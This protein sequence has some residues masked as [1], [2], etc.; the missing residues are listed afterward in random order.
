[1]AAATEPDT[2]APVSAPRNR[3]V[4]S[5]L[6]W[7]KACAAVLLLLGAMALL[8]YN[9]W[10]LHR[11]AI[12]GLNNPIIIVPGSESCTYKNNGLARLEPPVQRLMYGFAL[13]WKN[14]TPSAISQRL[15]KIAPAVVNAW[16]RFDNNGFNGQ[17]TSDINWFG[18]ETSLLGRGTMLELTML[19]IVEMSTLT[20]ATLTNIAQ[21]CADINS[22]YAVP[23]LL[24]FGHEM[25]GN[26]EPYGQRPSAYVTGFRNM[27]TILRKYTNLTAMVWA[28]NI[29]TFYPYAVSSSQQLPPA[30]SVDF[31]LLDTNSD[32]VIDA[33]DDPYGPYYPGDDVIDWV[34]LS[35]YWYPETGVSSVPRP[36]TYV[37]DSILAA[38]PS[39]TPLVSANFNATL[40]NF[41]NRFALGK[42]KPM[43]FPESGAPYIRNSTT[44]NVVEE[45]EVKQTWWQQVL[46]PSNLAAF[47]KFKLAINFE[48]SKVQDSYI[49]DW[50]Q[51]FNPIVR[52]AFINDLTT[53]YKDSLIWGGSMD[54]ACDG[55]VA[56]T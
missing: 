13:D 31:R 18:Y 32:G 11:N 16:I 34:G 8:S 9:V 20:T 44:T 48:E 38:G 56:M 10:R 7:I 40:H 35:L 42:N 46:S 23:I 21:I 14:D 6:F 5:L 36:S 26:W 22:K 45:L 51:T 29:G 47:P 1:M 43:C 3:A 15:N 27:G 4:C 50:A 19:P 2:T 25:N 37:H 33:A 55:S 52:N 41:Y 12:L 17:S 28:P 30:G 39:I 54:F 53:K 24:R 49:Q